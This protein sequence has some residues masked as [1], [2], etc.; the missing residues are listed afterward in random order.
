[1]R[2]QM[3]IWAVSILVLSL[4]CMF[5]PA[6]SAGGPW[7]VDPTGDDSNDCLSWGTP[8]KTIQAAVNKAGA[9]ETIYVADGT[10]QEQVVINKSLTLQAKEGDTPTILAPDTPNSYKFPES[11]AWWEPVVIAFGGTESGGQISGSDVVQVTIAGFE[12]DGNDRQ[13]TSGWRSAGI[14]L[15]NVEGTIAGNTVQN[16]YVDGAQTFGII[17]YG[18]SDVTIEGNTIS[19]YA[20]GGITANGDLAAQPDPH[21]VIR[22]NMVTG[23]GLGVP[24][25]WAP[26]GI[27]IGWGATG[28]ILTNTVSGNGWPGTAWT[29]SGIIIAGSENVLVQGNTVRENE[30]AISVLGDNF[31]G[32]GLVAKN[33]TI[34]GNEVFSNTYGISLQ[35]RTEDTQILNNIITENTYD[36]IDVC[37]FYGLPPMGTVIR[38]NAIYGNNTANDPTSGGLWV[39]SSIITPT[40]TVDATYNWWGDASGPD[41]NGGGPG[42]GDAII[43]P[44]TNL[45]EYDPWLGTKPLWQLVEEASAGDTIILAADTYYPGGM[46]IDKPLTIIGQEGTLIGPG[47]DGIVVA[48][49]DVAIENVTLDGT[50]GDPGD[51]GIRVNAGVERLRIE[52]CEIR[53]WPDDGIHFNGA[54]TD[55]KIVNNYLHHNGGDGIE[56]NGSP[57]GTVQIYGNAFRSNTGPGINAESGSVKAEYNEWGDI[58]GPT[59]TN[60]DGV[61]GDVDYDPW[62]FGKVYADPAPA[63]VREGETFV[64]DIKADAENL[65]GA[66]FSLTFDK[67]KLQVTGTQD[68]GAG[69]FKGSLDCTTTYSNTAGTLSFFCSH[70]GSDGAYSGTGVKLLSITFEAQEISGTSME[71]TVDLDASAVR[72]GAQGGVNIYVDSVTDSTVTI[73]GTT[74]VSGRVDLQGRTNDAGADVTLPAGTLYDGGKKTTD[75]WGRYAFEGVTDGTYTVTVEMARYLDASKEWEIQGDTMVLTPL[76]LLGGDVNDSDKIDIADLASIGGKFGNSVDPETTPEDINYDAWVDILDLVLAAGNYDLAESPWS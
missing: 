36:G 68:S 58:A 69:Y 28:K 74:D 67:D 15:R 47:S 37:D 55:L 7:Y 32:S 64:L 8:C 24:V 52:D 23:P 1:M 34:Q 26:N 75:S 76:V 63:Q 18:D 43:A 50:G 3:R 31:F 9:G 30:T 11:S 56:F 29:G 53:N 4:L 70:S 2:A 57:A 6:S 51:V 38:N 44:P 21:A 71:T 40:I 72:L 65:Y 48:A 73:Y 42:T 61:A 62:V 66:Q 59:G 33:V 10:Y 41:V 22:N 12:V 35:D 60:G 46:V 13:P 14:L 54:I 45:P 17:V 27:Q 25:T 16:M 19:G 20:R 39:D 49:N 5:S